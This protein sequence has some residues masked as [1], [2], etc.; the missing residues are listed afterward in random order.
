MEFDLVCIFFLMLLEFIVYS[1]MVGF[2][3]FLMWKGVNLV[4]EDLWRVVVMLW[5]CVVVGEF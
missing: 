3:R 4:L 5:E 2:F 1:C